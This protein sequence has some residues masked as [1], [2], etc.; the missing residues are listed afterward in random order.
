MEDYANALLYAI[1]GF[2]IL[3]VIEAIVAWWRGVDI[4]DFM[5]THFAIFTIENTVLVFILAFIGKDFAQYWS[6]RFEHKINVFWNRHI[7]HHSSEEFNLSCAL[8]QEISAIIGVSCHRF[9]NTFICSILVSYSP[10]Q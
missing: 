2:V 4:Y 3:I 10:Y 5:V 9:G 1:P 7:V 8:R 6:H